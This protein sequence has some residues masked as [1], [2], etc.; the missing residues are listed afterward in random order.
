M[1]DLSSLSPV[2]IDTAVAAIYTEAMP[3]YQTAHEAQKTILRYQRQTGRVPEYLTK[4][5]AQAKAKIAEANAKAQPYEDEYSN[6]GGW[7]RFFLVPDGHV[8]YRHCHTLHPTTLISWIPELAAHTEDE[9][10]AKF[11]HVAC[12]VCFPSAPAHPFFQ[13]TAAEA[14]KIEAAKADAKCD[15]DPY[16]YK[17]HTNRYGHCNKCGNF[18]SLTSTGKMRSHKRPA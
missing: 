1:P 13:K 4:R 18:T 9:M 2:E 5:L 7:S 17:R 6:R 16:D 15:A 8:H 10:V 12:T 3:A 14:A 11:G